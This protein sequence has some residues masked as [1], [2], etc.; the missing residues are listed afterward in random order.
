MGCQCNNQKEEQNTE[1]SKNDDN[2]DD[3]NNN[4]QK[5]EIFGLSNQDGLDPENLIEANNE[6]EN[7]NQINHQNEDKNAKYADY[8]K[9]MLE[10]INKIRANPSSY[11]DV[12]LDGINNIII[13]QDFDETKPKII[14]KQKVKV[15]LSKGEPAFREAAEILK[16]MQPLPALEFKE[17]ICVPLPETEEQLNDHS[18]L[19]RQ[20]NIIQENNNIDL[21]FKDLIKL[22]EVS[23]LLMIVDDSEKNPGKKRNAL[24]NE[25]FKYIGISN[26]FI[27]K[28]FI[29]YFTF[30]K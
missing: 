16:E 18:Y 14:Y 30:S 1:I 12:V 13:N 11:A 26:K 2:L 25:E 10:L 15:A 7:D 28:K 20:I 23:T 17:E 5:D 27:G 21:F 29:A 9:K 4:E 24:L 3:Y 22:P 6:N 8:P 19:K